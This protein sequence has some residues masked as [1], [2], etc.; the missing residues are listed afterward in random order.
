MNGIRDDIAGSVSDP[1]WFFKVFTGSCI[2]VLAPLLVGLIP[3]FGYLVRAATAEEGPPEE[4]PTWRDWPKTLKKGLAL[5][6]ASVAYAIFP[7]LLL[8]LNAGAMVAAPVI[9]LYLV[10]MPG[11]VRWCA[12]G[13]AAE[14]V[15]RPWHVARWIFR[16]IRAYGVAIGGGYALV[17]AAL[18]FGWLAMIVGWP[19]VVFWSMVV[20]SRRLGRLPAPESTSQQPRIATE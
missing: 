17:L 15:R 7:V 12:A 8:L 16:D 2:L 20:F 4:L 5:F 14:S 10:V 6:A 18:L 19:F 9:I 13:A 3:L 1:A 11:I